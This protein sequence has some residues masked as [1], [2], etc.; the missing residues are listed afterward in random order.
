[1]FQRRLQRAQALG[2]RTVSLALFNLRVGRFILKARERPLC[3]QPQLDLEL[4]QHGAPERRRRGHRSPR[5]LGTLAHFAQPALLDAEHR[6]LGLGCREQAQVL[7]TAL[8]LVRLERLVLAQRGVLAHVRLT[9][10]FGA[11]LFKDAHVPKIDD[12]L[13]APPPP[14][15]P[16]AAVGGIVACGGGGGGGGGSGGG[17]GGL[18]GLGLVLSL[19]IITETRGRRMQLCHRLTAPRAHK[20]ND[21]TNLTDPLHR[22]HPLLAPFPAPTQH[23]DVLELVPEALEPR[24]S[25]IRRA[26]FERRPERPLERLHHAKPGG[27]MLD[28]PVHSDHPVSPR[29]AAHL[30]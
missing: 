12:A 7:E 3:S 29:Q 26:L 21:A 10:A 18:H 9:L 11:L 19:I 17:S 22:R 16:T 14:S 30:R 13:G 1:M 23:L 25:Q 4:A 28:R 27:V 20:C 6:R 2:H 5:L 8:T 15:T 24:T